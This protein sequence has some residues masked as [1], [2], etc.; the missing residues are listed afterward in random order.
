MGWFCLNQNFSFWR[1]KLCKTRKLRVY[2][3]ILQIWNTPGKASD[4]GPETPDLGVRIL[5]ALIWIL[6][7]FRMF[8]IEFRIFRVLQKCGRRVVSGSGACIRFR[9]VSK[10]QIILHAFSCHMHTCR[11]RRRR[12]RVRGDRRATGVAGASSAG[13][14]A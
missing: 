5:R 3:R 4:I 8:R 2:A 11:R 14:A 7:K 10:L 6:R 13:R 12:S 9:F 1:R